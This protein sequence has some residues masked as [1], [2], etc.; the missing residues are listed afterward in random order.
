MFW[1]PRMNFEG[2]EELLFVFSKVIC[3]PTTPLTACFYKRHVAY[4]LSFLSLQDTKISP[5]YY[6][7]QPSLN[8]LFFFIRASNLLSKLE[9]SY[10]TDLQIKGVILYT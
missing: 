5:R 7:R 4:T 1:Q 6:Q 2:C 10:E 8:T 9:A 3:S